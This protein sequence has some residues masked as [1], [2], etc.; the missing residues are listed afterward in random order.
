MHDSDSEREETKARM[1]VMFR[2][3]NRQKHRT[4]VFSQEPP[5]QTKIFPIDP[6][7]GFNL[8]LRVDISSNETSG[9]VINWKQLDPTPQCFSPKLES[10]DQKKI[11]KIAK[12]LKF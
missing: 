6:V 11:F 7:P 2:R 1:P 3:L 12:L 8:K 4:R 10:L 9:K 5:Q